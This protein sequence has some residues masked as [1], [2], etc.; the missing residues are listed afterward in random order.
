MNDGF[1]QSWSFPWSFRHDCTATFEKVKISSKN[2]REMKG[3]CLP[4]AVDCNHRFLLA[5]TFERQHMVRRVSFPFLGSR[6][7]KRHDFLSQVV[8]ITARYSCFS[9]LFHAKKSF[10]RRA[11]G[12][13]FLWSLFSNTN[14][15][16]IFYN[17]D[18]FFG[19]YEKSL[20]EWSKLITSHAILSVPICIEFKVVIAIANKEGFFI[21]LSRRILIYCIK[22]CCTH[23]ILYM[24]Q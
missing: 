5:S 18:Q 24:Q 12:N 6:W 11:E 9:I 19:Y 2:M 23:F 13:Y 4:W 1:D 22:V 15:F 14:I 8:E 21:V 10:S 17:V 20:N 7:S 3:I 16:C